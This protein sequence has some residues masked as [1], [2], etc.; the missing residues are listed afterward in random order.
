MG[1]FSNDE[2]QLEPEPYDDAAETFTV[3]TP[4]SEP[5]PEP[6]PEPDPVKKPRP[7]NTYVLKQGDSPFT[8]AA[9]LY[10][11][12]NRGRE[13]VK[14]NKGAKWRAGDIIKLL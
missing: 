6:E 4:P 5:D 1:I 8:V 7:A 9:D 2:S 14:A 3:D 12:G 13:L 10:G 11:N